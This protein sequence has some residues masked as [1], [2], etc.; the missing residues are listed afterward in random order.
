MLFVLWLY[1]RASFACASMNF[2]HK[3]RPF[4]HP[5]SKQRLFEIYP[6][7]VYHTAPQ[8]RKSVQAVQDS[9][10]QHPLLDELSI[11]DNLRQTSGDNSNC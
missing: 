10:I 9:I 5:A 11:A 6:V 1:L 7:A 2:L 3:C 4:E 8:L